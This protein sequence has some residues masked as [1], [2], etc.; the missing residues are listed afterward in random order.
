MKVK[1]KPATGIITDSETFRIMAKTPGEKF[2]GVVP[3]CVAIL[4]T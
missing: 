2:V 4:P 3:T 1:I